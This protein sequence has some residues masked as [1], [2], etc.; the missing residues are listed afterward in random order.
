MIPYVIGYI[1]KAPVK[2]WVTARLLFVSTTPGS[3]S[4][5]SFYYLKGY[6]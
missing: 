1:S 4:E 2:N 5:G 6:R 3:G